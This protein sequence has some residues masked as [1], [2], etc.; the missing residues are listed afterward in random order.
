MGNLKKDSCSILSGMSEVAYWYHSWSRSIL[1]TMLFKQLVSWF[2]K[3]FV[4]G[5]LAM[6]TEAAR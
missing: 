2:K 1:T 3:S 5:S 4:T 6:A